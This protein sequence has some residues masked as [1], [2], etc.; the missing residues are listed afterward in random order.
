MFCSPKAEYKHL[1]EH[2]DVGQW[3]AKG[4]HEVIQTSGVADGILQHGC[5]PADLQMDHQ[6]KHSI[7]QVHGQKVAHYNEWPI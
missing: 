2:L 4:L 3:I 5:Y 1:I 7:L 6:S